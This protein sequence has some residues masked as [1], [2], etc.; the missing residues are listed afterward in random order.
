M[1]RLYSRDPFIDL[2]FPYSLMRSFTEL[3]SHFIRHEN[4]PVLALII[5]NL[6]IGV[7][8]HTN[9]GESWDERHRILYAVDSLNAYRGNETKLDDEKGPFYVM[10]AWIGTQVL[11]KILPQW[12]LIDRWHWMN[13]LSFQLGIFFLYRLCR[14]IADRKSSIAATLLFNT[15]PLIWGHSFINPK[16]IPFMAFFLGSVEMGLSMTDT[17]CSNPNPIRYPQLKMKSLARTVAAGI[18]LGFSCAIRNLGFAS[19]FLVAAVVLVRKRLRAIPILI[20]YFATGC[21]ITYILWPN[22]WDS[23]LKYFSNSIESSLNFS[24]EGKVTFASN[25]Y[26]IGELPRNYLPTLLTLQFTEPVILLFVLGITIA[27]IKSLRCQVAWEIIAMLAA[28]FFV[29]V[30]AVV[31]LQ[32]NMYDNFRQFLFITPP[33]FAFSAIALGSIFQKI[34]NPAWQAAILAVILLPGIY[35]SI[36]LHPYQYIYY[37]NLVGGAGGA[38]R[39]YDT[40]YWVTSYREVTD[41][42]NTN[43]GSGAMIVVWGPHQIVERFARDDLKVINY[44][45]ADEAMH[46]SLFQGYAVISSRHN[47][48]LYLYAQSPVLFQVERDGAILAVVKSLNPADP[49]NP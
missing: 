14:R 12:Q 25:E 45:R 46:S 44:R 35:W 4:F 41:F 26:Q 32:P 6:F 5:A 15:Q 30:I 29:P 40:D 3:S 38:F 7:L 18:F 16:D 36:K 34:R 27:F 21:L 37:N 22:L 48:D 9:Y 42:L 10:L 39:K 28:W 1:S 19:G 33:I 31:I 43:T 23:P 2:I 11:G 17:W 24:W 49:G 20:M 13:F 47:K 8:I